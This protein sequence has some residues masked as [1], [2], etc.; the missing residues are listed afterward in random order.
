MNI[1]ADF[2]LQEYPFKISKNGLILQ[3]LFTFPLEVLSLLGIMVEAVPDILK[4]DL[5][6]RFVIKIGWMLVALPQS[7][8]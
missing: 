2:L 7:L 8:L 1:E 6:E 4:K 5:I 3:I